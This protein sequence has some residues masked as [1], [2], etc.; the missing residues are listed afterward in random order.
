[1]RGNN[2]TIKLQLQIRHGGPSALKYIYSAPH[3]H[4]PDGLLPANNHHRLGFGA[5]SSAVNHSSHNLIISTIL[6]VCSYLHTQEK[7]VCKPA[8]PPPP[9]YLPSTGICP[10][11]GI[12]VTHFPLFICFTIGVD[13]V[14]SMKSGMTL[15]I[16]FGLISS[17]F[18]K[19][20]I[21]PAQVEVSSVSKCTEFEWYQ[22]PD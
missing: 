15:I 3:R 19:L 17:F 2:Q 16:A 7:T 12:S 13:A 22:R 14:L 8:P 1:M 9:A 6:L 5:S 4:C 21:S 20:D 18:N 10:G 11:L